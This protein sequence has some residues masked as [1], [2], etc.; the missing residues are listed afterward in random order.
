VALRIRLTTG[1]LCVEGLPTCISIIGGHA[2]RTT[3]KQEDL[4]PER[5]ERFRLPTSRETDVI[6]SAVQG[7]DSDLGQKRR[8]DPVTA[9][10]RL[11][12]RA[13]LGRAEADQA[14]LS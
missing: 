9:I 10:R 14:A 11:A 4:S 2:A 5:L 7:Q 3:L 12:G 13:G 6:L 8:L 1:M